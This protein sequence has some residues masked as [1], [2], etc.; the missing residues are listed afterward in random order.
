MAIKD[1]LGE[2]NQMKKTVLALTLA[3]S[4]GLAACSDSANE[5]V[6]TSTYGDL[7]QED[8]YK[9]MKNIAGTQFLEQIMIEK[10][11]NDKYKVSEKDVDAEFEEV[12]AQFG[13]E[14]QNAL[15]ESGLTEDTLRS[16]I[17]FNQLRN[18]AIADSITD[19][20]IKAYYDQASMELKARHILVKDEETANEVIEKLNAGEDFATLAKE[21]SEDTGSAENG[22]D[23][24][25]F[26]VGKMVTEFNDAAYALEINEISKP[27]KSQFGYH[28][29]QV[30]D[31]REIEDFGTL[32]EK[33]DAIKETLIANAQASSTYWQ[34]VVAD[35]VK[36]AKIEV[37]DKDLSDAF[38][39]FK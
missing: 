1:K 12:K 22:G 17:K 28:I 32:E 37:K 39:D 31:K 4:L 20:D 33:K 5:V 6:L 21:L 34:T 29:I 38:S 16:N 9:E 19:E 2:Y 23:L 30:T 14:F 24:D 10:I 27:V 13:D 11:L 8:F 3:A 15:K 7:T 35:L 25:W 26:T 36:E 18:K